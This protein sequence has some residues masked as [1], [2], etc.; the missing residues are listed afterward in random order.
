[1][2]EQHSLHA[3]RVPAGGQQEAHA[4]WKQVGG[5]CGDNCELHVSGSR[6]AFF[7]RQL[8]YTSAK[9]NYKVFFTELN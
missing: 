3:G 7:A 8:Y 9:G 4:R 6:V 5:G 2:D 1:M